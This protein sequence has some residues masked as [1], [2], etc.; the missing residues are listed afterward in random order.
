MTLFY[1]LLEP[2][3]GQLDYICAGHPFPLLRRANGEII[4]LGE[5]SLPLGLRKT[6][7]PVQKSVT[8][9]PG[10][11]LLLF[12]DGLPESIG[13]DQS[14]AFG[15]ERLRDLVDQA[16]SAQVTHDR[17]MTAFDRHVAEEPIKDDLTTV[18]VKRISDEIPPPPAT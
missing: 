2:A 6:V 18:V 4:E 9:A 17:V 8:L 12:T 16:G 14:T 5:G 13:S 10:D 11:L 15:F 1:A 7:K 3:S